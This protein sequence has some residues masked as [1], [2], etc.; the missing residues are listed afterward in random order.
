MIHHMTTVNMLPLPQ[1]DV[2]DG[3]GTGGWYGERGNGEVQISGTVYSKRASRF[4]TRDG[5]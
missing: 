4:N 5:C 2:I 1:T 3:C